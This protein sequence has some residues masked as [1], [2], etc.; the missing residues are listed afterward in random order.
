MKQY[1]E[2]RGISFQEIDVA[3]NKEGREEMVRK[4]GRMSVPTID[5]DGT[6]TIGFDEAALKEKLGT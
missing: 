3:S 1:L 2:E 5:I 4:T 6:I